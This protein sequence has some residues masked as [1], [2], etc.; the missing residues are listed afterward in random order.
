[1]GRKEATIVVAC[2]GVTGNLPPFEH[3][4]THLAAD[5]MNLGSIAELG[6]PVVSIG[7]AGTFDGGDHRRSA[8]LR[9]TGLGRVP[10]VLD[11]SAQVAAAER[12]A[13][14]AGEGSQ[15]PLDLSP[16]VLAEERLVGGAGGCVLE[17]I[18][19]LRVFSDAGFQ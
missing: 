1:M 5:F 15:R 4:G 2:I 13:Q 18:A 19:E 10:S 8:R 12:L 3:G 6:A 11:E 14:L 17:E 9:L 7:D 16:Q